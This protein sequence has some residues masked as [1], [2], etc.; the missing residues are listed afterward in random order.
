MAES[1][2]HTLATGTG[3]VTI[4]SAET[5]LMGWS[6]RESAGTPAVAAVNIEDGAG[7]VIAA[8]EL[9]ANGSSTEWFGPDGVRARGG[10]AVDR[11]SGETEGAVYYR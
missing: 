10:L 1:V 5:T 8:I 4:A 9:A 6:I 3:D 11:Q 7:N 2:A